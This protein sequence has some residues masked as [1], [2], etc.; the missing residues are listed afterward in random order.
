VIL[1]Q[2]SD[3]LKPESICKL[4]GALRFFI[5]SRLLRKCLQIVRRTGEHASKIKLLRI[6]TRRFKLELMVL[7]FFTPGGDC[8]NIKAE[9]RQKTA[10]YEAVNCRRRPNSGNEFSLCVPA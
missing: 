8:K 9:R 2:I 3:G 6:Q 10:V 1:L 7:E 4:A 5:D